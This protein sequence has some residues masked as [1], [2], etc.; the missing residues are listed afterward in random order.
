MRHWRGSKK[1]A[2]R[3]GG[4]RGRETR[5]RARVRTR[6][7]TTRAGKAELTKQ[8][9]D[10]EREKGTHGGNGSATGEPGP[11]DTQRE[12]GSARVKETGADRLVPAGRERER[13][14]ARG[15]GEL[16]LTGGVRLSGGT[17]ARARGLAGPV[18]AAFSF[19]FSLD[20]LIPFPFLFY[21]VFKSKFKLGF[22][23]K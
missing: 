5:R 21:R 1:G 17:G 20:F 14:S 3:V 6:R 4:R 13:E 16:P 7:S 12:R 18:W 19:S 15:R 9:H 10:V 22:N 23:F 2:G 11:R 8:A